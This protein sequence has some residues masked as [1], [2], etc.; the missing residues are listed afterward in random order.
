MNKFFFRFSERG[1]D[2]RSKLC[3]KSVNQIEEDDET[4]FISHFE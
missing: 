3:I 4:I 2:V 1:V